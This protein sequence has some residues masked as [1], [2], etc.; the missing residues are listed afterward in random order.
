MLCRRVWTAEEDE[1]IKDL[2][3][4]YGNKSWAVI[5]EKIFSDYHITGRSGKQCRERWHNH[6]GK[7]SIK[8]PF[9][10]ISF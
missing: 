6:L 3:H 2:V 5:S 7:D 4:K 8:W 9:I 10:F 1:A